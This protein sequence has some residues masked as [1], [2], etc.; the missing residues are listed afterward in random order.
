MSVTDPLPYEDAEEL[1]RTLRS[2]PGVADLHSGTFG[3]A[4]LLYPGQRV[5]GLRLREGS[6]LEVHLVADLDATANLH[7]LAEEVRRV[8]HRATGFAVDVVI[9][10]AA[11]PAA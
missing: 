11:S 3:E 5:R 10:D 9:A 6:H 2:V 7:H 1:A 4:S 8:A